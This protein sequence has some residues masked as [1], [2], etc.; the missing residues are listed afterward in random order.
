M[1]SEQSKRRSRKYFQC[2]NCK[3]YNSKLVNSNN[4]DEICEN[5]GLILTKKCEISANKYK[6]ST[7]EQSKEKILKNKPK[8][9]LT[10]KTKRSSIKSNISRKKNKKIK[11]KTKNKATSSTNTNSN[12]SIDLNDNIRVNNNF[13]NNNNEIINENNEN[14]ENNENDEN[15]EFFELFNFDEDEN[16]NINW[17]MRRN[18]NTNTNN[19]INDIYPNF[20]VNPFYNEIFNHQRN[21]FDLSNTFP[22]TTHNLFQPSFA[23]FE[24]EPTRN[25]NFEFILSGNSDR[26]N[27]TFFNNNRFQTN[28]SRENNLPN[29]YLNLTRE[30]IDT[31]F[32]IIG[33]APLNIENNIHPPTSEIVLKNLKKFKMSKKYCKKNN[34]GEIETPNCCICIS[35]IKKAQKTVLLP[36]EHMFHWNCCHTWLKQNNTCPVCRLELN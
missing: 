24:F 13:H 29:R 8:K 10:K 35:E 32:E 17:S 6:K 7:K 9:L 23:I 12:Q 5:C 2:K 4:Y 22:I 33:L 15:N 31:A 18:R 25:E 3:E 1:E 28:I 36:C 21:M 19:I 26:R 34:K 20:S 30:I 11:T 14:I 16:N 27:N